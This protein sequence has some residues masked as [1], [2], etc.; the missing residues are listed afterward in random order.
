[1]RRRDVRR[2]ERCV[3]LR[4]AAAAPWA[5][6]QAPPAACSLPRHAPPGTPSAR[7]LPRP[8]YFS[9]LTPPS[10]PLPPPFTLSH[11]PLSTTQPCTVIPRPSPCALSGSARPWSLDCPSFDQ[12]SNLVSRL[13]HRLTSGQTWSLDC[14]IICPITPC[15][16]AA[17][18]PPDASFPPP[19]QQHFNP[20]DP[21]SNH[22]T[23]GRII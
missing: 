5:A 7:H 11:H 12:W 6:R 14:P 13:P 4:S 19:F 22:L 17:P 18:H 23:S 2:V 9:P 10:F 3:A 20:I 16:A 1:V 8:R 21:W 15:T